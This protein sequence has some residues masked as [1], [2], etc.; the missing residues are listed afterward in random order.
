MF[1]VILV[2]VDD[3]VAGGLWFVGC[4][5][6]RVCGE[7]G[8]CGEVCGAVVLAVCRADGLVTTAC[9]VCTRPL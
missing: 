7:G 1:F 2:D 9:V 3:V 4:G 8:V 6:G 5:E